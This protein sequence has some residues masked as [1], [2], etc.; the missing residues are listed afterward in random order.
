VLGAWPRVAE[1]LAHG[2]RLVEI[3]RRV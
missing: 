1:L 2:E 3:G